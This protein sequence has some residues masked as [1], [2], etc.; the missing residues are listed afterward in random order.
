MSQ[1]HDVGTAPARDRG[2]NPALIASLEAVSRGCCVLV[3]L[4]GLA[5]LVGW[6]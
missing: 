6:A 2:V 3:V 5:V 4:V 1:R